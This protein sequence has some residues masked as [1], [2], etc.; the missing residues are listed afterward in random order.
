MHTYIYSASE[1]TTL[2]RYTNLFIIIIIIII[3]NLYS[4]KNREALKTP[5]PITQNEKLSLCWINGTSYH[6][7]LNTSAWVF[8][9][10]A[11]AV[12]HCCL[13]ASENG[14][15]HS[16]LSGW[17]SNSCNITMYTVIQWSR[18]IS[19]S[20]CRMGL[21]SA[22]ILQCSGTKDNITLHWYV[23]YANYNVNCPDLT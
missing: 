11:I 21:L 10:I 6:D 14:D 18:Y 1:V 5:S 2:R 22:V 19:F 17:S 15:I 23:L 12:F 8:L 13:I 7:E 20:F 16:T 3:I 9:T 4:G